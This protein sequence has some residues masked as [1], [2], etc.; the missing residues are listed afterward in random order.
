VSRSSWEDRVLECYPHCLTDAKAI[1]QAPE[2]YILCLSF[3]DITQLIDI[4]PDRGTYIYSSSEAHSEEQRVDQERLRN[5]LDRFNLAAVG[6][7][8]G[9]EEG[10][11]HASGHIDGPG[12]EWVIDTI[13]PERMLPVH[14]QQLEW[15]E[16]RWPGQVVAAEYGV[17]VRF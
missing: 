9:G 7:L 10:P 12:M 2:R 8:P 17:P 6:G 13:K 4:E 3:W 16:R 11:F 14:T 5:W 1:R 15:F